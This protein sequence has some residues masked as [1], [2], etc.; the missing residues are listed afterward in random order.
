M[1][2]GRL[3]TLTLVTLAL[4]AGNLAGQNVSSRSRGA[5]QTCADLDFEIDGHP[6]A[7]SEE[8][9]AVPGSSLA[10]RLGDGNG[11]PLKIV[12]S[13]RSGYEVLLCKA[14]L[15]QTSLTAVRLDRSGN[16]ISVSGPRSGGWGGYL[17]VHAPVDANLDVEAS[18]GPVAISGIAGRLQASISNGPLSLKNVSGTVDARAANGPISFSGG[19]GDVSITA[20]NGPISVDLT[21]PSWTSGELRTSTR[22]GPITISIPEGYGSG[23]VVERGART[24]FRCPSSLCGKRPD[25]FNDEET[26]IE[27]GSGAP[28][29]HVAAT[30]GPI[31]IK[32]AR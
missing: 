21:G 12:G 16:E 26:R 8:R 20:Q 5:V 32:S 14:A 7:R 15:D 28:R 9:M 24:P 10:I 19:S 27:I 31:S 25:F 3:V 11:I 17:L 2:M 18:N 29:V 13:N 6:A 30:N 1:R 4:V 23:V 22:N